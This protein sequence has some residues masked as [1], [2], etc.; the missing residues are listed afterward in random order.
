MKTSKLRYLS[1]RTVP[2]NKFHGYD[3][4]GIEKLKQ[5]KKTSKLIDD[6]ENREN[7][8]IRSRL[9]KTMKGF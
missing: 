1:V 6:K 3:R 2:K 5:K 4:T 8:G 9:E 7:D